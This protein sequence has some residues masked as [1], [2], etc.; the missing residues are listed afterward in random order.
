MSQAR[1]YFTYHPGSTPVVVDR[2]AETGRAGQHAPEVLGVHDKE[3]YKKEM[4]H[5]L[6]LIMGFRTKVARGFLF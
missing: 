3:N 5:K 1:R 4:P 2:I 6:P